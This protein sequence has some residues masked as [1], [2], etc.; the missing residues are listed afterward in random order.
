MVH[1]GNSV[2]LRAVA[3][4][5]NLVDIVVVAVPGLAHGTANDG[6]HGAAVVDD[7]DLP[8]SS[9]PGYRCAATPTISDLI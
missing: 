2:G 8:L 3:L 9:K 4:L 5:G 6:A 1:D 7:Q